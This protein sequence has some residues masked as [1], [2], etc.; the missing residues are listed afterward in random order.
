MTFRGNPIGIIKAL[1]DKGFIQSYD[2]DDP[3]T[4]FL[5][6]LSFSASFEKMDEEVLKS[7]GLMGT[8]GTT[9][10]LIYPALIHLAGG[11]DCTRPRAK[12]AVYISRSRA[13]MTVWQTTVRR[14]PLDG[15]RGREQC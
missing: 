6:R 12:S 9:I 10:D 3:T 8:L 11:V 1:G 14:R 2:D 15:A 4:R 7:E 5:R 13:R